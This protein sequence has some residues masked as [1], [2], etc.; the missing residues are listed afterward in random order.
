MKPELIKNVN[1]KYVDKFNVVG[2]LMAEASSIEGEE[3]EEGEELIGIL[4]GS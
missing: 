1:P 3:R 4:P 2:D